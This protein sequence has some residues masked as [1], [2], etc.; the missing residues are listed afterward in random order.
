MSSRSARGGDTS[1]SDPGD[2]GGDGQARVDPLDQVQSDVGHST[3]A[4]EEGTDRAQRRGGRPGDTRKLLRQSGPGSGGD[5]GLGDRGRPL[6]QRVPGRRD[7]K[8]GAHSHDDGLHQVLE[9]LVER[10]LLESEDRR[11]GRG[12]CVVEP[13][14]LLFAT[15]DGRGVEAALQRGGQVRP[16]TMGEAARVNGCRDRCDRRFGVVEDSGLPA[17]AEALPGH[18]GVDGHRV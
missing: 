5:P 4:V 12:P 9:P 15:S 14:D 7:Q 18:A 11:L 13:M 1:V 3:V 6:D 17:A 10:Q 16:R 8:R 2:Q